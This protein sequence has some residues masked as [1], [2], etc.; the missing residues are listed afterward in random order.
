VR[1][2]ANQAQINSVVIFRRALRLVNGT[3]GNLPPLA[4]AQPK[5]AV[6]AGTACSGGT[7][8]GF[9]VTSENPIYVLGDYNFSSSGYADSTGDYDVFPLC[10][11]PASV[12]GDTVTLLSNNWTPGA[13]SGSS[14]DADSFANP[15]SS[16]NRVA[17]TTYY[18]MAVMAGKTSAFPMPSW[19]VNDTGTDGGV[20]NFLRYDETWSNKTLYYLGSM[21]SFYLSRQGTGIYKYG[22]GDT[23]YEPP[24]RNYWFDTDFQNIEKLPPGTPRFTDVNA[25]SYYQ[26]ILPN[27]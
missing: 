23:V 26:S 5:T 10:H 9:T 13:Q 14:G 6:P 20:H 18:R 2:T 4:L 11:V 8:G 24:T 12:Q 1:I 17:S 25:L 21:A 19:G 22:I 16:A 7:G 3:L 27:Q 15:T